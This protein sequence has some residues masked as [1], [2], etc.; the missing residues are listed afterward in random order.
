MS[1][2]QVVRIY[3]NDKMQYGIL[4]GYELKFSRLFRTSDK[5]ILPEK[6]GEF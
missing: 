1:L 6:I 3:M 4:G 2:V 5:D